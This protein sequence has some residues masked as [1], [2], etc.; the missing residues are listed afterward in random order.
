[1]LDTKALERT[2][3]DQIKNQIN[4]EITK[5][6]S[7]DAWLESV[8]HKIVRF[9]QTKILERFTNLA[10]APEII[11]SVKQSVTN[12]FEQGQLPG[13]EQYVRP[14]QLVEATDAAVAKYIDSLVESLSQDPTWVEK[15]ERMINQTIVQRTVAKIAATDIN[16]IIR[17]RVDENLET[18]HKKLMANFASNGIAD[19]AST[20]QLTVMDEATVVENQLVAKNLKIMDVAQIKDLTVTG[21]INTDNRSWHKLA[22]EIGRRTL[23]QIDQDWQERLVSQVADK[24]TAQ[25][26]DFEQINLQGQPL[27]D[28]HTLSSVVTDTNIQRLGHLRNLTVKGEA[29]IY[30]TLSVVNRRLGINTATPESAL[31]VWDEEV[32]VIIGKHKSKQAFMGTSR[33]QS[34][35]LGVNRQPQIEIDTTG[36]TRIKKLQVGLHKISHDTQVPGWAGTRGDIVFNASPGPDRVFAWVCL[37]AHKW[38]T[39]KSAE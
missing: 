29:H 14:E 37:G 4:D 32:A 25:G 5:I 21:S 24:I 8:E 38:Q 22:E 16:T 13:I 19:Q 12:L 35:V 39:L 23:E 10:V 30:D 15:V 20:T 9:T 6:L 3:Q 2:I 18:T 1:M 33:D 27:I 34:L 31:S 28:G 11:E 17:D 36:L 7:S 26:I